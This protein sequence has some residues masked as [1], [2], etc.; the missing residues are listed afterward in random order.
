MLKKQLFTPGPTEVPPRTLAA[1]SGQVLHHRK[2]GFKNLYGSAVKNLESIFRSAGEIFILTSSGT[3]AMET[4]VTNF[5][6]PGDKALVV[7]SGKFGQRWEELL[8][9]FGVKAEV[10]N[11]EWG[12]AADPA[13]IEKALDE[14]GDIKAVFA[15][16]VET[17]TGTL[18][19]VE[20]IAS[21]VKKSSAALII[22][23]ISGLGCDVI[24]T[25]KWEIDAVVAGSQKALMTPPG[26]GF[27]CVN[28]KAKEL[29]LNNK[30]K[31]YYWSLKKAS[32]RQTDNLTPYTPAVNLIAGLE[33]SLRMINSEGIENVWERHRV[34]SEATRAA[35]A[36]LGLKI[37]SKSP[38]RGLT[39]IEL[40]EDISLI[41]EL[42][43]R[44]GI[45]VSGGQAHLK[46][47]IARLGHMGY[48]GKADIL[49]LVSAI[50]MVTKNYSKLSA[51]LEAADKVFRKNGR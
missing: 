49:K 41:K 33:I 45:I 26:L 48:C 5:T 34:F 29:Y 19:P 27:I 43:E 24:E 31:N 51:A 21:I 16:L 44:F 15:T 4:A 38:A 42:N 47:K 8:D 23:A 9:T 25:D 35:L 22:D 11:Y 3:G 18:H 14:D 46:G 2:E 7:V 12:S 28:E 37:F 13:D 17:S 10:L 32:K 20:E 36:E 1:L 6:S 50:G 39:T 40:P 30:R